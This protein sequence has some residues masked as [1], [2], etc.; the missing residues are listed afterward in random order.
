MFQFLNFTCIASLIV[1]F[2]TEKRIGV[3]IFLSKSLLIFTYPCIYCIETNINNPT[4]TMINKL[5]VQRPNE[6]KKK[7]SESLKEKYKN[8]KSEE[9]KRKV[10][11]KQKLNWL[12]K[13]QEIL[14]QNNDTNTDSKNEEK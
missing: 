7:I 6:V 10:S 13:K 8:G 3:Q 9:F 12:R 1:E 2:S 4:L 5:Q 14:N 11:E